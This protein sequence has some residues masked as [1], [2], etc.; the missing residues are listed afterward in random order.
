MFAGSST[1]SN[2][3]T[4]KPHSIK[5]WIILFIFCFPL[6]FVIV[7]FGFKNDLI[8]SLVLITLSRL[9]KLTFKAKIHNSGSC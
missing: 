7:D 3:R 5:V 6:S 9:F 2:I 1:A 4:I 8:H